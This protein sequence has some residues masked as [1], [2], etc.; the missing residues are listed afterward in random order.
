MR[1]PIYLADYRN[2]YSDK[3]TYSQLYAALSSAFSGTYTTICVDSSGLSRID[4]AIY[5][6]H[7]WIKI[8]DGGLTTTY[9]LSQKDGVKLYLDNN[10]YTVPQ[11]D[12]DVHKVLTYNQ[13]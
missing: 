6:A 4:I 9:R 12:P 1:S 3:Y 5:L 13:D 11:E 7:V 10:D 8:M 2:F